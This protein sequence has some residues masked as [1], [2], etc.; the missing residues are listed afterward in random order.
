MTFSVWFCLSLLLS[1]A[2]AAQPAAPAV[3]PP[4]SRGERVGERLDAHVEA[5]RQAVRAYEPNQVGATSDE[6]DDPFMDFTLSLLV[7]PPA[8]A[9]DREGYRV[10][11]S[12]EWQWYP[13]GAMTLRA[14]QYLTRK[15]APVVSK[16]FN[17]LLGL[18]FLHIPANAIP[19]GFVEVAYAHESNGQS[20]AALDSFER[21]RDLHVREG[22]DFGRATRIARDS[23]S[24]GW[25]YAGL[26]GEWTVGG[27]SLTLAT[28][29]YLTE[30]VPQGEK[31]EYRDWEDVPDNRPRQFYDGLSVGVTRDWGNWVGSLTYTTGLQHTGEFSTA[32]AEFGRAIGAG[33]IFLWGRTGY[34]SGL[35]NY[36]RRDSG[37]G[38]ALSLWDPQV[39]RF[40]SDAGRRKSQRTR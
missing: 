24:R 18:R 37:W 10:P 1:A 32:R 31:E 3:S 2:A 20:I 4:I 9:N 33:R 30:S 39:S 25:D 26:K 19:D 29:F 7:T 15:S 12:A 35:I 40:Y 17:P 28:R 34:N 38:L 21:L 11:R 22:N 16:R 6:G 8:P 23:I 27:Y 14:G 13:L 36:Y 5:L